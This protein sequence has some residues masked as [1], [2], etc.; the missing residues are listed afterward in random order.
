MIAIEYT[1]MI[2]R[3]ITTVMATPPM[4]FTISVIVNSLPPAADGLGVCKRN[5]R[6]PIAFVPRMVVKIVTVTPPKVFDY[7][8]SDCP[9]RREALA[10]FGDQRIQAL[11]RYKVVDDYAV[12]LH[13]L[14]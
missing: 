3:M 4:F 7:Y 13:R 5:R 8:I 12:D 14:S 6:K 9:L 2:S 11:L 1:D 10:P